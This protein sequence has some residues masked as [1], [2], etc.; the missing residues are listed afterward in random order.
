M[1]NLIA[2]LSRETRAIG[3]DGGLIWNNPTDLS[4]FR[5]L[6]RAHPVIMGRK[7]WESLPENRRPLPN[8]TNIVVSRDASYRAEGARV[9]A[10]IEEALTLAKRSPGGD[11]VWVI[12]GGII[13]ALS[14]PY[15]DR[16]YLTLVDDDVAGDASFPE[17]SG[18]ETLEESEYHFDE[19]GKRFKFV[20][21]ARPAS[22]S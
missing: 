5:D 21:L 22:I 18:F 8:R 2:I 13:Y 17:W 4:R 12:G 9:V 19:N 14:L 16:L 20:T 1:I 10:T 11:E 3:K 7:T 15:A 6:T